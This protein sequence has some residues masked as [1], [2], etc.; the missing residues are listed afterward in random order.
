MIN[1]YDDLKAQRAKAHNDLQLAKSQLDAD[2]RGWKEEASPLAI[3][4][5]V[6][7]KMVKSKTGQKGPAGIGLQMGINALL[8]RTVL[9][10]LPF[11]FNLFVPHMAQ[12]LAFNY[13]NE[14][15]RGVLIKTLEWVRDITEE[16]EEIPDTT[17]L[18]LVE[19]ILPPAVIE[20]SGETLPTVIEEDTIEEVTKTPPGLRSPAF[21]TNE[22]GDTVPMADR[23]RE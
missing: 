16:D 19:P 10:R 14:Y 18:I 9:K 6:A 15:G 7:Q 20:V 12:N 8:A 21:T 1:S 13:A 2:Q 22:D 11:P 3:V 23:T 17:A 4:S 5:S